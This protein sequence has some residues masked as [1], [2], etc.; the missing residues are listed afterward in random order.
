MNSE[1]LRS[2]LQEDEDVQGILETTDNINFEQIFDDVKEIKRMLHIKKDNDDKLISKYD[3][4]IVIPE[5]SEE[6]LI[7]ELESFN[8]EF[9]GDQ[10][11]TKENVDLQAFDV[12]EDEI[13][14]DSPEDK[15]SL[16]NKV[17][18]IIKDGKYNKLKLNRKYSI[19]VRRF[20]KKIKSLKEKFISS[21]GSELFNKISEWII[22]EQ[23]IYQN[24]DRLDRI[25]L[26]QSNKVKLAKQMRFKNNMKRIFR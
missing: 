15:E 21:Y 25:K 18:D 5:G 12:E 1:E 19:T 11:L 22:E 26:Y 24:L 10:M 7:R 8:L 6:T 17:K 9:Y 14:V 2:K 23:N 20:N 3:D 13:Y 4:K 16:M